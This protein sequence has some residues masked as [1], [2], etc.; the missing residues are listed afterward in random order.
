VRVEVDAFW[1]AKT[2]DEVGS[3]KTANSSVSHGPSLLS[4][5]ATTIKPFSTVVVT[6][7]VPSDESNSG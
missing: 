2:S 7:Y 4:R 6:N 5:N 1:L 3:A